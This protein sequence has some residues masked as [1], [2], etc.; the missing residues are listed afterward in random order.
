MC[1]A[2]GFFL[3]LPGMIVTDRGA[4]EPTH[5]DDLADPDVRADDPAGAGTLERFIL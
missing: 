3:T 4:P 2:L 5:P 1:T